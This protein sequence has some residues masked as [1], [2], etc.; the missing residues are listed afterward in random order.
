M[1]DFCKMVG[2]TEEGIKNGW[3]D[4]SDTKQ[5]SGYDFDKYMRPARLT[6]VFHYIDE[7][8]KSVYCQY[9]K[10]KIFKKNN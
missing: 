6:A 1:D 5:Q 8:C 10:G 4:L 9:V 7:V 2:K 3:L